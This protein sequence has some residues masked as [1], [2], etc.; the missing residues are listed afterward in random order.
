VEQN[1]MAEI[2]RNRQWG[3]SLQQRWTAHRHHTLSEEAVGDETG[4]AAAPD[5]DRGVNAVALEV[6]EL[7][8][9]RDPH[10]DVRMCRVEAVKPRDE[11]LGREYRGSTQDEGAAEIVLA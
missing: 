11:P 2:L 3:L 6:C 7:Q 9:G 4:V 10:V 5:S 1:V 8:R